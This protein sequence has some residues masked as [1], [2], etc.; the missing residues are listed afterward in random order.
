MRS[1]DAL[2]VVRRLPAVGVACILASGVALGQQTFY[3]DDPLT[4][5]PP[6]MPTLGP[7]HRG[8]SDVLEFFGNTFGDPGERQPERGVIPAG[9]I[10]TLDEVLDGPWY[11]NRHATRR[12]TPEELRRGPGNADPPSRDAPWRALSARKFDVRP[13]ILIADARDQLYLL[14]FDPPGHLEMSTGA[15][16]VQLTSVAPMT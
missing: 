3:P 4:K 1:F 7:E 11:V 6:P 9:G 10:N 5:E 14:R 13:G 8:L 16:M 15:E 12:M 2:A